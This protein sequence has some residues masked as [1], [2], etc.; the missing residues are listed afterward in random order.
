MALTIRERNR[1]VAF[2][3]AVV[4]SIVGGLVAQPSSGPVGEEGGEKKEKTSGLAWLPVIFYTPE[5]KWALGGGGIYYFRLTRDENVVRPSSVSFIAIYSQRKQLSLELNPDFYLGKGIHLQWDLQYSDFPDYFYGIGRDTAE[6]SEELYTSRFW[7]LS[8]EALKQVY[9]DLNVGFVYYFDRAKLTD[10]DEAPLLGAGDISGSAGGIASGLG[11][12]MTY[13]S[14]DSIFFPTQGSFHQ[15][16]ATAFGRALGSDFTFNRF[17]LDLRKYLTLAEAHTLALQSKMLFQTGDP[18]FWRLGLLGGEES[19]RGYYLGR[20]RDKN[21][22]ALQ[23]EYRWLPVFWRLGLAAFAGLGDVAE[24]LGRFDLA[25]LKY[26]YGLGL[27]FIFDRRQTLNIRLDFGFGKGTSGIY[28][29]A[30]EAF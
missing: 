8:V 21:L 6:E 28:F 17:Y 13:D 18:P 16:S 30:A 2:S 14:R 5:T 19:M 15:F 9:R 10:V 1:L 26:S 12:F 27:R 4:L 7:K 22:I 11:F 24:K 23:A 3:L 29:T 25:N 20:Y